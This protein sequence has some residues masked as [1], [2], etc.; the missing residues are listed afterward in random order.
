MFVF[1]FCD[2][3]SN[4]L[5][6][7]FGLSELQPRSYWKILRVV[8]RNAFGVKHHYL[9]GCWY[10]YIMRLHYVF[11]KFL[12]ISSWLYLHHSRIYLHLCIC[13][14]LCACDIYMYVTCSCTT[15]TLQILD[16][17]TK[18]LSC[19]LWNL[20][21]YTSSSRASRG[22]KFQKKKTI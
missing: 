1:T 9:G 13:R 16:Q 12:H 18:G 2:V 17:E 10:V 11:W 7:S 22:R 15:S 5:N 3:S 21:I 6:F 4:I 8:L 14:H 20:Y 19:Y